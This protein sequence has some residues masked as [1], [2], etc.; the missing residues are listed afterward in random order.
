MALSGLD[1]WMARMFC[2]RVSSYVLF[3]IYIFP[4][5]FQQMY[6]NI[7]LLGARSLRTHHKCQNEGLAT[8]PVILDIYRIASL[9][10]FGLEWMYWWHW[11]KGGKVERIDA[12]LA[13]WRL[14][15][16]GFDEKDEKAPTW[17]VWHT[18]SWKGY[19]EQLLLWLFGMWLCRILRWIFRIL[20]EY[21]CILRWLYRILRWL[22]ENIDFILRCFF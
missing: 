9:N 17:A 2:C 12:C 21:R 15:Y 22:S 4:L 7:I 6:T 10:K 19:D 3:Y 11:I 5:L 13:R 20:R 8:L 16:I 18:F 1:R 14:I